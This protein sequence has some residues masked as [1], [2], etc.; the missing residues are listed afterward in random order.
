MACIFSRDI[1]T[2]ALVMLVKKISQTNRTNEIMIIVEKE[3]WWRL[4][5]NPISG[6]WQVAHHNES[7]WGNEEKMESLTLI[8]HIERMSE[9]L[10][11]AK[12]FEHKNFEGVKF[13]RAISAATFVSTS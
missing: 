2:P 1:F 10:K 3:K 5:W 4:Y 13:Y 12:G 9:E 11:N 8:K 7:G 6:F